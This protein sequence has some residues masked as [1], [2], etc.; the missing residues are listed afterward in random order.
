MANAT[1]HVE[2][3]L[4][5]GNT[6]FVFHLQCDYE[7]GSNHVYGWEGYVTLAGSTEKF[8]ETGWTNRQPTQK[9]VMKWL[10]NNCFMEYDS[11]K[12]YPFTGKKEL[13]L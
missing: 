11:M 6:P 7:L 4:L 3:M 12:Y 13:S 8:A 2:T 9:L 10:K 5:K 1:H